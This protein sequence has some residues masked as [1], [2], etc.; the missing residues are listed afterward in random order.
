VLTLA[1]STSS[2]LDGSFPTAPVRALGARRLEQAAYDFVSSS[3]FSALGIPVTRGRTFADAEERE[4]AAVAIVSEA[5]ARRLWPGRDPIG[6]TVQL[7]GELPRGSALDR[8]R[9]AQVVGVARNAVSGWIGTGL[10]RPVVYFPASVD[11]PGMRV[12]ARVSG[13]ASRARDR[14]DRELDAAEP[15]TVQEIHTMDDY[16]AVQ[17]YPFRIFSWVSGAL[18]AIALVL[19]VLG[20][21]GVLS[22]VVTQRTREIGIRMALGAA[23]TSVVSGVV[24]QSLRLAGVGVAVGVALALVASRLFASVLVIVNTFDVPGY[25]LGVAVVLASCVAAAAAPS[26][27]AAKVNPIVALKSD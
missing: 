26:R 27:R 5:A 22:Y 18:G 7:A 24:G 21:Y 1:G 12:V 14:L 4:G 2:P 13:D 25:L 6:Q 9:A 19:T 16:L 10:D 17:R 23:A 11:A 15:G 3:Y 20:I 8:V